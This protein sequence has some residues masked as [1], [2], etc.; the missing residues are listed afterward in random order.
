MAKKDLKFATKVI[1]AG[2]SADQ[3]TGAVMTQ[4]IKQAPTSKLHLVYIKDF[5]ILEQATLL[6]KHWRIILLH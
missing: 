3:S 4:S 5:N 6:E 2:L 1:H